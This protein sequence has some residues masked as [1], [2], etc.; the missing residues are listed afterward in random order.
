M[1]FSESYFIEFIKA[2]SLFDKTTV[3]KDRFFQQEVDR[4]EKSN[5]QKWSATSQNILSSIRKNAKKKESVLY[6]H[7]AS[8]TQLQKD[9]F[10]QL[11]NDYMRLQLCDQILA[12][13]QAAQVSIESISSDAQG[14]NET[15]ITKIDLQDLIERK[16]DFSSLVEEIVTLEKSKQSRPLQKKLTEFRSLSM[17]S[18]EIIN[19][20]KSTVFQRIRDKSS[21]LVSTLQGRCAS[22]EEALLQT[23]KEIEE[24]LDSGVSRYSSAL[25]SHRAQSSNKT[26]EESQAH[27]RDLNHDIEDLLNKFPPEKISEAL[28]LINSQEPS[29]WNY[30]C[31]KSM[32]KSIR[33]GSLSYY[34]N[35]LQ[36]SDFTM[37]VLQQHY[38]FIT[39]GDILTQPQCISFDSDFSYLFSYDMSSRA[40]AVDDACSLGM[41][42]FM[43][44]PPGK[45]NFTFADPVTL[46]ESFAMFTRLVDVDDRTSGVINGKIWSSA[47]DIE[48]KL[49][50]LTSHISNVTQRCLQGKYQNIYDYNVDAGLNAEPYQI[51]MLM[52]YPAGLTENSLRLIEQITTSGP[53]CGVFTI[54]FSNASQI[55]KAPERI[56]PLIKNIE[57]SFNCYDYSPDGKT[58][59]CRNLSFKDKKLQWKP[60]GLVSREQMDGPNGIL[61]KLKAGIKQSEKIV[62]GIEKVSHVSE[63]HTTKDGIHIP[64]GIRGANEVQYLT[65]G[66]GGSHHA[67]IAGVAGAGKSS[68][69]HTIILQSLK[70]YDP[71][72]LNIYL[73]DF[74]RGVEFKIYADYQLPSFKVVAIESER[75]F[76]YNILKA[77]EREQKIRADKFKRVRTRK[78]DRIEDYR[79][80]GPEYKMPRIL[81]ILDEFHE[82]FSN[83]NDKIGRE[84]AEMMER[85]VRQGRAFGVHIILSS[86]SYAN[87]GGLDKSVYDQMA[88]RIVLKCSKADAT[89]L[90]GDGSADVDQISIDDPG[91]AI[92]NS[93][94]GNKEYNSHFRVAFIDPSKHREILEEVSRRTSPMAKSQ[95]RILLSSIEDNRYSIFNQFTNYHPA[96][97]AV[98]GRLHVGEP[99]SLVNNL[100]MD[101]NRTEYSNLLMIGSDTEKARSMF[102]FAMLSLGINHWVSH[103]QRPPQEQFIYFLN[104]KP[105]RDDYFIDAPGLV[106]NDYLTKYVKNVPVNNR[107]QVKSI[108]E[109]LYEYASGARVDEANEDKYLMVFGYQRAEDLKSEEKNEEKQDILSM[110]SARPTSE[111]RSMKEML[112]II[113]TKGPQNG[114]HVIIWQD[115]FKA[116]DI[117][118]RKFITYFYQRIAFDMGAEDYSQF[119]GISDGGQN[120]ENSAI[121]SNRIDDTTSFRPYQTPDKTWIEYICAN[122]NS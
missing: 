24:E 82:L 70:Q 90:L 78:I 61:A 96:D 98:P 20:E 44:L 94:A 28:T 7:V 38:P 1:E 30:E 74:K 81:V 10:Q 13:I 37:R 16:I 110:M 5:S 55:K 95:T 39:A 48:E 76:G 113:L 31:A 75:E 116:L 104:Y 59:Y 93:E 51:L 102:A 69:L 101:L 83:T 41:R 23:S 92:Y 105:L 71:D 22:Y 45:V 97:C 89:M 53:K 34:L 11:K 72:E 14:G 114:V 52:D 77:L 18:K 62:I 27:Q 86:Q 122:L 119:V 84:S 15:V 111:S 42:L 3:T 99:L 106:A 65:L 103:A 58:I 112:E 79:A 67:L 29:P 80:L 60:F 50:I 88:V 49:K 64:I 54:I 9:T 12:E 73:V 17:R 32:P 56:R 107:Q 33:F 8:S 4:G 35:N 120:G 118:D 26:A 6:E 115:D 43:M 85:I 109:Y 100:H 21:E 91:R 36:I 46:G 68:L 87:V 57:T 25:M 66:T 40:E 117:A 63:E 47:G 19:A 2:V 108:I 121:Y